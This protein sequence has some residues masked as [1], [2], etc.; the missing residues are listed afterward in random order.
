MAFILN[1]PYDPKTPDGARNVKE[2]LA[3]YRGLTCGVQYAEALWAPD[4][5]PSAIL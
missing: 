2:A 3:R 5:R 1:R 4:P